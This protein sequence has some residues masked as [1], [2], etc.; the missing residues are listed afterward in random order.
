M[1][2]TETVARAWKFL[3]LNDIGE[4][5]SQSGPHLWEAGQWYQI[6]G[7]PAACKRGFHCS[8]RILDAFSYVHGTVLAEVE[9]KGECDHDG[10]KSAYQSMRIIR[11]WRFTKK[12]AV[13]FAIFAAEQVIGI[14]EAKRPGDERPRKAIEAAKAWLA[15]PSEEN[16]QAA[17]AA[18]ASDAA[19]AAYAAYAYAAYAAAADAA[20]AARAKA[21]QELEDKLEAWLQEHLAELEELPAGQ[22][23]P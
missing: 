3:L 5:W 2:G 18:Y 14:F 12:D 10:N 21:R 17:D 13:A 15:D 7:R 4:I 19:Y 9:A 22:K 11:A 6:D 1:P 16:R 20:A 23:I 8:P